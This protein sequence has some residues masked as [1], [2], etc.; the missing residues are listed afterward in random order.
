MKI[1]IVG[2]GATGIS[3]LGYLADAVASD[4]AG[5]AVDAIAIYDKCGFDG[6]LAYRTQNDRHLLNMKAGAMSA[7]ADDAKHFLR[8]LSTVGIACESNDHVPRKLYK[9]YLDHLKQQAIN[10]CQEAGISVSVINDEVVHVRHLSDDELRLETSG[11]LTLPSSVVVLC[12]GHSEPDDHYGLIGSKNYLHDPYG[13]TEFP[14]REDVEIGIIGAGLTAV[15]LVIA[16]AGDLKRAKFCN[17]S[18]SGLFPKVQPVGVVKP[19]ERFR[20]HV[21]AHIHS[22]TR[23]KAG[24]LVGEIQEHLLRFGGIAVDL[25][26]RDIDADGLADLARN[27][28]EARADRPNVYSYLCGI[29]DLM[30]DAWSKMDK[31]EKRRFLHVY[32]SGWMRN[33]HAMPLANAERILEIARDHRLSTAARLRN[34]ISVGER[35]RALLADGKRRDLD[36]V[37]AATGTSYAV[38]GSPLYADMSRQGLVTFNE[39]GGISC[40]YR[41]G[42][43]INQQRQKCRNI[44]AI[45]S[46]TRG[47]HFYA[48]AVDVNLSRAQAVVGSILRKAKPVYLPQVA[49]RARDVLD[50][51]A[52]PVAVLAIPR[53]RQ[54]SGR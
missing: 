44:Y 24:C 42:R 5:A 49:A 7:K 38:D 20:A 37:I 9:R 51:T 35:F 15:D 8:W 12:T 28:E 19:D 53:L 43:V 16:L 39:F 22:N 3:V 32:Y 40:D 2:G 48:S 45:G 25:S 34:V 31:V 21:L 46:I 27:V 29:S 41:D 30:C 36:H 11:R 47:T 14:D 13:R 4:R 33:R 1:S 50:L 17:L 26:R 10:R 23:V 18:R 54:G 6:G 52:L